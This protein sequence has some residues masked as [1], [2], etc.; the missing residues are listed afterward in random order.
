MTGFE[1]A[2]LALSAHIRM[3]EASYCSPDMSVEVAY[4][5]LRTVDRERVGGVI[6]PLDL[7][8]Y[9][10]VARGILQQIIEEHD[11]GLADEAPPYE[12]H[13]PPKR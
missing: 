7:G 13:L 5:T 8:H 11:A 4:R 3:S 6:E 9:L 1:V 12:A 2:A 10:A